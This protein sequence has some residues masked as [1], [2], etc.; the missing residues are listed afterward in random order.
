[1]ASSATK[2]WWRRVNAKPPGWDDP[3][4]WL[5]RMGMAAFIGLVFWYMRKRY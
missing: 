5:A 2:R 1:M 3:G 4:N